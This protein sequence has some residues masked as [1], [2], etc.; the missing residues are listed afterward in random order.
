MRDAAGK[1]APLGGVP[2]AVHAAELLW[3]TAWSQVVAEAGHVVVGAQ[4]TADV[5]LVDG[6][7]PPGEARPVVTLGGADHDLPGVLSPD[8]GPG[9]IEHGIRAVDA[10]FRD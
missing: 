2:R 3:R 4:D 10:D 8:A 9:Q 6:D 7:C 5:V 1:T